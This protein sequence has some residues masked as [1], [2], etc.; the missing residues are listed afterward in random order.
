MKKKVL[1][2]VFLTFM[3]LSCQNEVYKPSLP[4]SMLTVDSYHNKKIED[5]YRNLENLEDSL[6]I[7]WLKEQ[8]KYASEIIQ[9]IEGADELY[10]K[11]KSYDEIEKSDIKNIK[12]SNNKS[13][14]YL[15]NSKNSKVDFLYYQ[16]YI[17]KKEELLFKSSDFQFNSENEYLINYF[18]PDWKDEKIAIS[19]SKP[20]EDISKIIVLDINSKQILPGVIE[21]AKP[22]NGGVQ[23]LPDNSGFV[24][25]QHDNIDPHSDKYLLDS[26][27]VLYKISGRVTNMKEVFSKGNNPEV[28]LRS[29][30]YPKV[31]LHQDYHK[32]VFGEIGGSSKYKDTYYASSKELLL[33]R[34]INWKPLFKKDDKIKNILIDGDSLIFISNKFNSF[35]G[36]YKTSLVH[37]DFSNPKVLI[38]PKEEVLITDIAITSKGLFFV[39][40]KNGV[41]SKLYHLDKNEKKEI[42]LGATYGS[43]YIS[44][45]GTNYDSLL[46]TAGGW[47]NDYDIFYFNYSLN[48]KE[49]IELLK[50]TS[51]SEY[52]NIEVE[53]VEISSHDGVKVPL[54]IIYKKGL[55]KNGKNHTLFYGYG[56]YGGA[57]TPFFNPKLLRWVTEGGILAIAHVR[58][59][60][61]KGVNWYKAGYKKTKPNTWKDMIACTEYMIKENYTSSQKSAI[62]G[63]SAGGIMVGRAMTERPDLYSAVILTSPAMNML[64]SEIQPN[65]KNSIKEFGTVKIKE[66][67]EALLEMDSYH[68]I[69]EGVE[70][71]S[72]YVTG[73]MKDGRVVIWDPA[74]FVARLQKANASNNPI[75]FSV[76]FSAGHGGSNNSKDKTY[77]LYANAFSFAFWQTG[78]PDYQPQN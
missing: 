22:S 5:P 35:G 6:V 71:P 33:D 13:N 58:G 11:I 52:D 60:G 21:N 24:F 31:I 42:K 37:P 59:G 23:W 27:S 28:N 19:L 65:G 39:K 9:N 45:S 2:S 30:D 17:A 3:I 76:D 43:I 66:E 1:F 14:F 41:E 74:K 62:W 68:N 69:K 32:Y 4:K 47:V 20:G 56:S 7:S 55:E 67:F 63:S 29:E 34:K 53:E 40:F 72:T 51:S 61:E 48:S 73:G 77:A 54:S 36:I 78:H 75:I 44:S 46:V 50:K 25:I 38:S 18:K 64:R 57:G 70:Y 8:D 49:N 12:I 10:N 26:K 16:N 15:R